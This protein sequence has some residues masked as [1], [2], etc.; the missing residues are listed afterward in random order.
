MHRHIFLGVEITM[1]PRVLL[2]FNIWDRHVRRIILFCSEDFST[3]IASE[4]PSISEA[5][6]LPIG[7]PVCDA[8][9][10]GREHPINRSHNDGVTVSHRRNSSIMQHVSY[11]HISRCASGGHIE[12]RYFQAHHEDIDAALAAD[13]GPYLLRYALRYDGAQ[14]PCPAPTHNLPATFVSLL[15]DAQPSASQ[16]PI[17]LSNQQ[18]HS[19]LLVKVRLELA[20][21]DIQSH[22]DN[23]SGMR[24]MGRIMFMA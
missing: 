4:D 23:T 14:R 1:T 13:I 21:R 24:A 18:C 6:S 5:Y 19:R 10:Y 7:S 22:I 12:I 9:L 16:I 15:D 2:G 17:D 11:S 3:Y 8:T 20:H